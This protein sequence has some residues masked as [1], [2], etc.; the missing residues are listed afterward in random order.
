MITVNNLIKKYNS[1]TALDNITC[2]I[3]SQSV[4]GIVG[5]NGAGKSTLLKILAKIIGY[6][7]G[8]IDYQSCLELNSFQRQIAY[9]PEQRG[10][11]TGVDIQ[12]QLVFFAQIRGLNEKQAIENVA[13]W[14][15]RLDIYSWKHRRVSELSKGMQQKVQLVSCLVSNPRIMFL[16]E[17]FSGV[18][19][20]NFRL[21][22]EVLQE[23]QK[24][25]DA[26]I[27][28]STHNMMSVEE[29]CT[30]VIL[31]NRGKVEI[32][33]D[34]NDVKESFSKRNILSLELFIGTDNNA[35]DDI[36]DKL[37]ESFQILSSHSEQGHL[38]LDLSDVNCSAFSKSMLRILHLLDGYEIYQCSRKMMS[39]EDIFIEVNNN[40]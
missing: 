1:Q 29:L 24:M 30:E 38:F 32:S 34:V 14:L 37:N 15:K 2:S 16:D 21:F 6:D 10:L 3:K 18:D 9:L 35:L 28:L 20:I 7:S 17:P 13:Y 31:L 39:M 23:Y 27:V 33:G 8:T 25:R 22:I 4:C 40:K 5:P 19:P 26:T 12:T 11:Y 36:Q